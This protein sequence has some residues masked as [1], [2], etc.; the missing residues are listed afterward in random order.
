MITDRDVAIASATRN[1]TPSLIVVAEVITGTL[2]FCG[3]EDDL[4]DA[5]ETMAL[6]QV[7]RL[8]V[9]TAEGRVAG[10]FSL[11][12]VI[13]YAA[14]APTGAAIRRHVLE[15]ASRIGAPHGRPDES[16][17]ATRKP[18]AKASVRKSATKSVAGPASRKKAPL[19]GAAKRRRG[20][21]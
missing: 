8:P 16:G 13:R 9:L 15:A 2:H 20:P 19:T 17:A 3:P 6:N 5:L 21:A 10:L 14:A 12:D 11:N 4:N 18:D 1:R 7:R